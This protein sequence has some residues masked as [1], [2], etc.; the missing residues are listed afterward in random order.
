M[1]INQFTGAH[2]WLSN[3]YRES[4]GL[5]AEHRFQAAK[6]ED[7]AEAAQVLASATPAQAKRR[8]RKVTLRRDWEHGGKDQA[9]RQALEIK[10]RDPTLR[11]ALLATDNQHLQEDNTWHDQ[12]WGNCTCGRP[13]CSALGQNRLGYALMT[14][15]DRLRDQQV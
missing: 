3:F 14:L 4:D 12:I 11:A 6:T 7:P 5:T 15:R 13:R 8:G 2:G 1:T 10:F 9:M